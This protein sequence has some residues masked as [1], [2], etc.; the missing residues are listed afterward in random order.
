MYSDR[1][2]EAC[3][4]EPVTHISQTTTAPVPSPEPHSALPKG[5]TTQN[6]DLQ[7]LRQEVQPARGWKSSS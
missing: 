1:N 3:G 2:L 5:K 6:P 7:S 4:R